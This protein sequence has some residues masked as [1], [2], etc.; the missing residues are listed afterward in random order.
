MPFPRDPNAPGGPRRS[1]Y[2]RASVAARAGSDHPTEAEVAVRLSTLEGDDGELLRRLASLHDRPAPSGPVV[3]A[4]VEGE[5]VAA[6]SLAD[7]EAVADPSRS[8][9]GVLALLHLHRLE[10]RVIAAVW[11]V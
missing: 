4:E 3:L 8:S 10:A 11:G 7:G 6:M 1:E 9:S 2:V 5:P